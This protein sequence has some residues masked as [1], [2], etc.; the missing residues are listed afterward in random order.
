MGNFFHVTM[1]LIR[2]PI[3]GLK[4][5]RAMRSTKTKLKTE[6]F[7][8]IQDRPLKKSDK[9]EPA[10]SSI[11]FNE[12]SKSWR[13]NK[14]DRRHKGFFEYRDPAT[15]TTLAMDPSSG[16][17]Y[18]AD[19]T[20]IPDSTTPQVTWHAPFDEDPVP[21]NPTM[22]PETAVD[23]GLLVPHPTSEVYNGEPVE[24]IRASKKNI[25]AEESKALAAARRTTRAKPV[26][27]GSLT[28]D[29]L[30]NHITMEGL[31]DG[32]TLECRKRTGGLMDGHIDKYFHDPDGVV[33][34]SRKAAGLPPKPPM[35][36]RSKSR[37]DRSESMEPDMSAPNRTIR[38]E[39]KAADTGAPAKK[40]TPMRKEK[41]KRQSRCVDDIEVAEVVVDAPREK[42]KASVA[43]RSSWLCMDP[44]FNTRS[45]FCARLPSERQ[46]EQA[47]RVANKKAEANS[48]SDGED[49]KQES[50]R[51]R[52]KKDESGEKV[53]KRSKGSSASACRA[54][55]KAS[56][57][58]VK[59]EANTAEHVDDTEQAALMALTGASSL[60][61]KL[62]IGGKHDAK[63][64]HLVNSAC[65]NTDSENDTAMDD[66]SDKVSKD[67]SAGFNVSLGS[68]ADACTEV[69][70]LPQDRRQESEA[71]AQASLL[72]GAL[73]LAAAL[74]ALAQEATVSGDSNKFNNKRTWKGWT[75]EEDIVVK[76]YVAKNGPRRWSQLAL[77]LPD[78]RGKDC[79]ERWLKHLDPDITKAPWSRSEDQILIDAHNVY[80]NK[81][82][83]ISKLL[84]G[85]TDYAIKNRFKAAKFVQHEKA[86]REARQS[87]ELMLQQPHTQQY[88]MPI[89]GGVP[90]QSNPQVLYAPTGLVADTNCENKL[91]LPESGSALDILASAMPW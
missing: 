48:D 54:Q 32:W 15:H 91:S 74:G 4:R 75:P 25:R 71:E 41:P 57:G 29:E 20:Q 5:T 68:E 31:P 66:A 38:G 65:V 24:F 28:E 60:S 22:M 58:A 11:D 49:I 56:G 1:G 77:M 47:K 8:A 51:S 27:P 21:T 79:R 86:M 2:A 62:E 73:G 81:W 61:P 42:R 14:T 46:K 89:D 59:A 83:I 78:R 30:D 10:I 90:D 52:T 43:A 88:Q 34:R 6:E 45:V 9:E 70:S 69:N 44:I 50:K 12:A 33:H 64:D 67:A 76:E 26:A 16:Y 13:A 84:P 80:G 36:V 3:A 37:C 85:R 39:L 82:S 18:W 55:S 19:V 35:P 63:A 17:F 87:Q 72:E 40:S 23:D 7:Q 53:A